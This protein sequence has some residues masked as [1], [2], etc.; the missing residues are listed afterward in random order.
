MAR[1]Q[2]VSNSQVLRELLEAAEP[3]LQRVVRM[4]DAAER[5]KGAVK[6]GFAEDLLRSQHVIEQELGSQLARI[7]GVS[8]GHPSRHLPRPWRTG[9]D[10]ERGLHGRG[11][12]RCEPRGV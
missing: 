10:R 8:E 12:Q 1:S 7:D 5:A 9:Y 3:A 11:H 6:A 2:R 4:I